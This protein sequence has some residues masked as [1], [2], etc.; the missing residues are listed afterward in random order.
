MDD[1]SIQ[2]INLNVLNSFRLWMGIP[3]KLLGIDEMEY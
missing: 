2:L 1:M 3:L